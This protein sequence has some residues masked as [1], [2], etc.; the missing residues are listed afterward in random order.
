[1]DRRRRPRR[2]S[3]SRTASTRPPGSASRCA[4]L[5]ERYS[6]ADLDTLDDEA[7]RAAVL[8]AHRPGPDRGAVG[9]PPAPEAGARDLRARPAAQPVRPPRRGARR[10]SRSSRRSSTRRSSRS[11]SP[12]G[13]RPT[14]AP[15]CCSP[16]STAW[17]G[18]CGTRSARPGHLRRQGAPGRP[19]RP[20]RD[21]GHLQPVAQPEAPRPGLHPRGL[22]HPDRAG[23]SSRASTS[24]STTR[25]G[26][27]RRRARPGMKAAA[28]GVLNMSASSTAGGTRAGPATT[29]GRSAAARRTPTRAPRTGPTRRTCTGS[30]RRRSSRAYYE[31]DATGLPAALDRAHAQ[32][33]RQHDLALLDDP[34]A[35][36]VRRAAV[37]ARR[38]GD[39]RRPR[40]PSDPPPRAVTPTPARTGPH[41]WPPGS[42]WPSRSTTT[43]RS[44]TSAGC[45]RRST[46]GPTC[47][48][49]RRSSATRRPPRAPLHGPAPRVVR[50]GAARVPR[51]AP[52]RS[53]RAARWRSSAAA[54]TS[55]CWR[56]S[57]S[58]TASASCRGWPTSSSGSRR[59]AAGRVAR[60]ARLGAGPAHGARRLPAT[61][62]RSSTT[63]TSAPP[64]SPRRTCGA[65]YTTE[66]Q[67]RLLTVFGTEQ[68]L[69]YRIPFRDGRGGHRAPARPRDRGRRRGSG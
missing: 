26:R 62:G 52:A 35:P 13:S 66:D 1:M 50:R 33:D 28:N 41:R 49:S 4:T 63:R 6:D 59:A 16:T 25:A 27:S 32:L 9:G 22:R 36:R 69:R 53:S 29:A 68:G 56:R 3:A 17:R 67:G 65:P 54:C 14:S 51:A 60:G 2:S 37:P 57:R 21:P 15:R 46:T 58:A 10:R 38:A 20:G 19:A 5:L 44:A 47:R 18:C 43:S 61:S 24:G 34:D 30:S 23:S 40:S 31:R 39:A 8:G 48:W 45:S 42:R 64:R 55:R 11:A 12:G 7:A